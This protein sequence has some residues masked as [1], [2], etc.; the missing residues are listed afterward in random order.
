[1]FPEKSG[2]NNTVGSEK[3]EFDISRDTIH[4]PNKIDQIDNGLKDPQNIT[5]PPPVCQLKHCF[6]FFLKLCE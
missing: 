6:N 4:I 3:E 1:M 5:D 2:L